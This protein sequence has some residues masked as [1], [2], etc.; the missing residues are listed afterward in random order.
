MLAE[1]GNAMTAHLSENQWKEILG[2]CVPTLRRLTSS[3]LDPVLDQR[4]LELGERKEYL[5]PTEHAE[6]MALVGFAQQRTL[7]KLEAQLAIQRLE[8]LFPD[9]SATL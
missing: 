4:M 7:E 3:Q 6:L 2:S 5:T 9:W 1:G 8:T